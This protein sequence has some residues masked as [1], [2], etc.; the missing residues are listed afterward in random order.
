MADISRF[1]GRPVSG[2]ALARPVD[3]PVRRLNTLLVG[4][5]MCERALCDASLN[6]LQDVIG[7]LFGDEVWSWEMAHPAIRQAA[8]DEGYRQFPLMPTAEDARGNGSD[9]NNLRFALLLA[10]DTYGPALAVQRGPNRRDAE[11]NGVDT[12]QVMA[13]RGGRIRMPMAIKRG[14]RFG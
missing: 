7:W 1:Q 5:V 11:A 2:T 14:Q 3:N 4:T 12:F 9:D 6:Q 8:R 10:L 13:G